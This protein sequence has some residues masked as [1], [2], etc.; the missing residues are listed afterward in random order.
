M[1]SFAIIQAVLSLAVQFVSAKKNAF[2]SAVINY[3]DNTKEYQLKF[4][5]MYSASCLFFFHQS[6]ARSQVD[7]S[8]QSANANKVYAVDASERIRKVDG[9]S[10]CADCSTPSKEYSFTWLDD[11]VLLPPCTIFVYNYN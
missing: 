7:R 5:H 8:S 4:L 2:I 6:L 9:N 1:V 11:K 3:H 10:Y